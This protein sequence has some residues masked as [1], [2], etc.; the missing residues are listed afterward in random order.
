LFRRRGYHGTS[1]SDIGELVALNK[2]TLYYY[3]PSKAEILYAIYLEAYARL[4]ANLADI[5]DTLAPDEKLIAYIRA[6]LRSIASAPDVIAVY[7][8]E[9]PW[10]ESSLTAEQA[11]HIRAEEAEFTQRI[12]EVIKAGMRIN[13]FRRV[14]DEL[15]S[16]QLLAMISSLYRWHVVE[17][18][19]AAELVADTIVSYL[20]EGILNSAR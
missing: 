6:I 13:I 9:H 4:D 8:Q 3:F 19:P 5:P 11:I 14:N 1:M 12:R 18:E 7:F 10:L 20:F 16:V 17:S 2:G 15:L